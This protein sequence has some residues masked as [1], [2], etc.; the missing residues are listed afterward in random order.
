MVVF[1]SLGH[2]TAT[3]ASVCQAEDPKDPTDHRPNEVSAALRAVCRQ[4]E[5]QTWT[6][7]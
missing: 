5:H 6:Q 2:V 1:G 4:H 3:I 7:L